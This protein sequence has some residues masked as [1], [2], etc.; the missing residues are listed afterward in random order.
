MLSAPFVLVS[1]IAESCNVW[2]IR[3]DI[4]KCLEVV[5]SSG[6]KVPILFFA[7]LVAAE[8]HRSTMHQGVDPIAMARAVYVRIRF[9][10]V[11]GA[12][13]IEQQFVRVVTGRF[14]RTLGRKAREQMLAIAVSRQREKH[15]I[16]SAYLSIAFYGSGCIGVR[17]LRSG[18]GFELSSAEQSDVMRMMAR[19]K[20]PQP[21]QPSLELKRKLN[22][23]IEYIRS[24]E[25]RSANNSFNMD[26]Q[27]RCFASLLS[28][29]DLPR[30]VLK[31][32]HAR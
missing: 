5:D 27:E 4:K 28:A 32:D 19:L 3:K 24:R 18:C 6:Q 29:G 7:S 20:Y 9:G 8:D 21:L 13:T 11:Q 15:Q 22:R 31:A 25:D 1:W 16:A 10:H 17:G 26:G 2:G 30:Q 12:S 23:R 14:D